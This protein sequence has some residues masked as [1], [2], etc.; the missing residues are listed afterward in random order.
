MFWRKNQNAGGEGIK[1]LSPKKTMVK[2]IGELSDGHALTYKLGKAY[3]GGLGAYA[4]IELNKEYPKKG[5]KYVIFTDN[6][7]DDKPAGMKKRIWTSNKPKDIAEWLLE[8]GG[9]RLSIG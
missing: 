6:M 9:T 5:K 4:L 3:W 2:E 8:K 1:V 7:G